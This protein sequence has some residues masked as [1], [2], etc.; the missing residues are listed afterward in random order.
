MSA[1]TQVPRPTHMA[2]SKYCRCPQP[3]SSRPPNHVVPPSTALAGGR[4]DGLRVRFF[5]DDQ[6][7]RTTYNYRRLKPLQLFISVWTTT[8]GWPGVKKWAGETNWNYVNRKPIVATFEVLSL[9][10]AR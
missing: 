3:A 6:L 2:S 10:N 4:W 7:V 9:P 1:L 8:G 5:V